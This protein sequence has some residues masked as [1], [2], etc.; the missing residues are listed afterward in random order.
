MPDADSRTVLE[1][2]VLR[3][4]IAR[5]ALLHG[6]RRSPRQLRRPFGPLLVSVG[7]GV[8]L[9][10]AIWAATRIITVME[11]RER[12]REQRERSAPV[13][14]VVAGDEWFLERLID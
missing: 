2:H 8:V 13:V 9:L 11:E 1:A 5:A 6:S 12:E 14:A 7:V 4:T 10:L 3:S